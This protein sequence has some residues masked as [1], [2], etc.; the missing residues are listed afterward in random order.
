[1]KYFL[2]ACVFGCHVV[3]PCLFFATSMAM[4]N[5]D[6]SPILL[7]YQEG[8]SAQENAGTGVATLSHKVLIYCTKAPR[9]VIMNSLRIVADRQVRV[10]LCN[11]LAII[12]LLLTSQ[13]ILTARRLQNLRRIVAAV[14][15]AAGTLAIYFLMALGCLIALLVVARLFVIPAIAAIRSGTVWFLLSQRHNSALAGITAA[16]Q[17]GPR[18]ALVLSFGTI[19]T[20]PL[21]WGTSW[22]MA[23]W[24]YQRLKLLTSRHQA[25][26]A[27]SRTYRGFSVVFQVLAASSAFVWGGG[28]SVVSALVIVIGVLLVPVA[29]VGLVVTDLG[30]V[31][32]VLGVFAV[33][34]CGT[35][36]SLRA[37]LA[38]ILRNSIERLF[39][40]IG[41]VVS[42]GAIV[43]R[44]LLVR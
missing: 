29:L 10:W 38:W 41:L 9:A 20:T 36:L 32:L 34:V 7:Q 44:D 27:P 26:A 3:I 5:T 30:P 18:A 4:R 35:I 23:R 24:G 2:L 14:H 39:G 43:L 42:I 33:C 37:L 21:G 6:T 22:L 1:M 16:R 25:P 8:M 17:F 11:V 19:A 12:G 28:W 15:A 31:F 13:W 40:V